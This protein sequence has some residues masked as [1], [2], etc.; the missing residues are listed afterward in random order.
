[1]FQAN[2]NELM[3]YLN[4]NGFILQVQQLHSSLSEQERFHAKGKL[5]KGSSLTIY[6]PAKP[7]HH[8]TVLDDVKCT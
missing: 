8:N 4:Q 5:G 6:N 7:P 1:M 3:K 2:I